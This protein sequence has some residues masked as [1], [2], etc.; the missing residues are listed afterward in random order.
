M[1]MREI[2]FIRNITHNSF[3]TNILEV[4][5]LGKEERGRRRRSTW[6][7]SQKDGM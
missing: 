5:V 3:I 7:S 4:K 6:K 1:K 2:K